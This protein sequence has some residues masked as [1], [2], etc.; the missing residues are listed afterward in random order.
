MPLLER[1]SEDDV[2]HLGTL[3]PGALDRRLDGVAGEGGGGQV[4]ERAA[5]GTTDRCAGG[6][7][8]D[9]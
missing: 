1:R 4:V 5:I 3:D 6:G 2:L 9:G 7:D 8:D